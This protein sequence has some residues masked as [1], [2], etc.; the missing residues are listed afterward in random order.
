M[1]NLQWI[2]GDCC[3]SPPFHTHT[4]K[5]NKKDSASLIQG[6]GFLP[7][8]GERPS[9]QREPEAFLKPPGGA[10]TRRDMACRAGDYSSGGGLLISSLVE[11][12]PPGSGR[13]ASMVEKL[14]ARQSLRTNF[15]RDTPTP[16]K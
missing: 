4:T 16:G 8:D 2:G 1:W 12:E 3:Q 15:A 7:V 13:P 10:W 5:H 14:K 9:R 6:P 11:I